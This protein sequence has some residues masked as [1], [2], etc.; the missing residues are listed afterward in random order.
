MANATQVAAET[1]SPAALSGQ[2]GGRLLGLAIVCIG[3]AVFWIGLLALAGW[4][5]GFSLAP[6]TLLGGA[7]A[8]GGFL[9]LVYSALTVNPKT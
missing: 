1:G 2:G 7:L 9:A 5:F 6:S 3:P 8:I 4:L